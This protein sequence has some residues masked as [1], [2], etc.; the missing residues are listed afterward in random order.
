MSQDWVADVKAFHDK[1]GVETPTYPQEPSNPVVELRLK[2]VSEE[3][4]EFV[5]AVMLGDLAKIAD[6]IVDSIYVLIGTA[7]AYG[8]DLRPVWDAVQE[9]NMAKVGGS[10]REDGKILKPPG[11]KSPD[12]EGIIARQRGEDVNLKEGLDD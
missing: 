8:I 3:Y 9:A 10:V 12:I 1:F 6:A 4:N 5:D 7:W 11:W 2:L